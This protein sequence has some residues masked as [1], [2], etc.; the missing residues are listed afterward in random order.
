MK[1]FWILSFCFISLL[2]FS[3]VDNKSTDE[4]REIDPRQFDENLKE[5]N[6]L[7][8][9][10]EDGQIE[11]YIERYGWKMSK[12]PSGLRYWIYSNGEGKKA[13]QLS[14]VR[15][16]CKTELINGFVCYDSEVDG[17]QEIQLG[18]STLPGGLE[19]GLA[20][21]RE[22]DKAKFILPSH[23]AFGLLGDQDKIPSKAIL[24][25]DVELLQVRTK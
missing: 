5:A 22:G 24:I 25:Y 21:M 4:K 10:S 18:K 17:Y 9:R 7:M 1:P 2:F 23:L 3:C 13:D 8:A 6:R 11:D 20:M 19:E 14:I 12:S 15:F 16:L